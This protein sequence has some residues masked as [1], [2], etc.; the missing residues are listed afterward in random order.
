MKYGLRPRTYRADIPHWSAL[1]MGADP[2]KVPAQVD[3]TKGLPGNLGMMLN[4]SL[5]CCAEAGWYHS[6]QVW[7]V[8][9]GKPILTAPDSCVEKL[10]E[11]T[12]Y[13]P[14]NPSTD[15]GTVLQTLLAYLVKTG[16]PMPDGSRQKLT[17]F[18]ELDPT[19]EAD[20]DR[21]T[22]ESGLVYI[23][24]SIPQYFEDRGYDQPG[25]IW[26]IDPSGDQTVIGGHCV[27]CPGY[28]PG[29]RRVISWGSADYAMTTAFWHQRVSE[30]YA[31]VSPEFCKAT[32][33][34]PLGLTLQTWDSQM[35]A[36]R[37]AA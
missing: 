30:A 26:D 13:I 31:L 28:R 19:N 34:T 12:G 20:I 18:V 27:I 35:Q 21:A 3:Y 25:S 15:R 36:L 1:K 33:K 2:I 32:G 22:Y 14:G 6:D 17:A 11:T 5:G 9:A 16:A 23:G 29:V 10:Y 8:A 4:A 37:M 7:S 24:F